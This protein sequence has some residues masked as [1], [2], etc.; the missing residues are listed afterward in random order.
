LKSERKSG[1]TFTKERPPQRS[2]ADSSL[3]EKALADIEAIRTL[4]Q[5]E[6]ENRDATDAEKSIL[7]RCAGR[8]A[9]ASAFPLNVELRILGVRAV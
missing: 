3:R 2:F 1:Y 7:V 8:G 6:T 4:K 9:M 5:I